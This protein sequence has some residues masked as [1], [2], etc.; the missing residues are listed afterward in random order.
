M[1]SKNIL[2]HSAWE[3]SSF[4]VI[5]PFMISTRRYDTYYT[6]EWNHLIIVPT[7]QPADTPLYMHEMQ[8][9]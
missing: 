5:S 8:Y 1:M 7:H 9:N 4:E 2:G 6:G 3:P